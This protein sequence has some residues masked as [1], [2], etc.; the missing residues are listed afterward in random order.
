MRFAKIVKRLLHLKSG[1]LQLA[2]IMTNVP[3][4]LN[5]R[6][7]FMV[8]QYLLGVPFTFDD[9]SCEIPSNALRNNTLH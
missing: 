6:S 5:L 7:R 9:H 4:N 2:K 3:L 8:E 1:A